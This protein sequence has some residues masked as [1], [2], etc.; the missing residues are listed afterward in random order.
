MEPIS[1]TK[2][3]QIASAIDVLNV[4]FEISFPII[5]LQ[6]RLSKDFFYTGAKGSKLLKMAV[7]R[8]ANAFDYSVCRQFFRHCPPYNMTV[9]VICN[10]KM[11]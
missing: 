6:Q 8:F 4:F 2:A 7:D 5:D 9:K 10:I 1:H 3:K 11:A